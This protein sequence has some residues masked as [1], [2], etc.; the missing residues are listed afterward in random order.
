[1]STEQD[2]QLALKL[3]LELEVLKNENKELHDDILR[4]KEFTPVTNEA[5]F[6]MLIEKT[7]Y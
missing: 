5:S 6:N 2:F 3:K 7:F 1:M 4:A